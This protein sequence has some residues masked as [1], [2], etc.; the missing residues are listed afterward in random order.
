MNTVVPSKEGVDREII[1]ELDDEYKNIM[2]QICDISQSKVTH[3]SLIWQ[4]RSYLIWELVNRT[5]NEKLGGATKTYINQQLTRTN[6]ILF[7]T[8]IAVKSEKIFT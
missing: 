6:D 4:V 7:R 2:S 3:I 8:S 5:L 1:S